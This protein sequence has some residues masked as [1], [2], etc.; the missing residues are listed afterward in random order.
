M[1]WIHF[2][3]S[4]TLTGKG[5]MTDKMMNT[6]QNYYGMAI[7]RQN[8]GK[9]YAMEKS[10]AV[11]QKN[12]NRPQNLFSNCLYFIFPAGILFW[13]C[14]EKKNISLERL[15]VRIVHVRFVH[16]VSWISGEN[17]FVDIYYSDLI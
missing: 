12:E 8:K 5:R 16:V 7:R 2:V 14:F 3:P 10:V 4:L 13:C 17:Y 6:L 11:S 9:L 1:E 15:S